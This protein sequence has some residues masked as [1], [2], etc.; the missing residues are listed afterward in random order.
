VSTITVTPTG[1]AL[2]ADIGGVDL[3]R[4]DDA[5]FA[6][7]L[8]AWH[9]N[10]VLRF[11]AQQ[12][13]DDA[14]AEFSRRFGVLDMAPTGRGGTPFNP[15]R[16]EITVLSN[17]VVDGAFTGALGNSELVWH[18]DMS[19]NDEP[20]KAS[21]L[22]AKEV[23]GE[24]GDTLFYNLYKAYETLPDDLKARIR[25]VRCKHDAT[26]NSSG[27]LRTG[28][29]ETYS[30]EERPGAIHPF[31]V[32]H[33]ATGRSA[34]YLGRRP[35]ACVIGLPA[36]ESEALLDALWDHVERGPHSWA[37]QW[38]AGDLVVWDNRC[39]LHRRDKIDPKSRRLMH[40]TQ[41]R[42]DARPVA[43]WSNG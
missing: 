34:L 22:H 15:S 17:I 2:G 35:N 1:A 28:Y 10:L 36:D 40:R 30:D 14:L 9:D 38:R 13:D 18:Q 4:I 43:A 8:E 31:V 33:P 3:R 42:D 20:P 39:T 21:L 27:E 7:I 32:R 16:P 6:K 41:V 29:A 12:L 37:Q 25:G 5:A 23:P 11:R 24:G 19:Y 26:R